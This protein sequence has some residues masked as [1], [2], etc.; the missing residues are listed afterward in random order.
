MARNRFARFA[1]VG[2]LIAGLKLMT[3]PRTNIVRVNVLCADR[4][5]RRKKRQ[6]G[7][8][9]LR[10]VVRP[11]PQDGIAALGELQRLPCIGRAAFERGESLATRFQCLRLSES[12]WNFETA[13]L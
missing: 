6:R 12:S 13:I 7:S 8:S 10:H 4:A 1:K 3:Q 5:L 9:E 2:R 11:R